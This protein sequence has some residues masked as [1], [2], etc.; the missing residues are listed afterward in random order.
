MSKISYS[1]M[2]VIPSTI[3]SLLFVSQIIIG[4]YLLS[5]VT[6]IEI[7]AYIGAG[8]YVFGG[9]IFGM[10]PVLEFHKKVE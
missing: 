5:D 4:I 8:L 2:D 9:G 10:L 7:I 1:W 3:T 6:Q